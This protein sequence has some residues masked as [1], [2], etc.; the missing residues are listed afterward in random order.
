LLLAQ[1]LWCQLPQ[2]EPS[3]YP[4]ATLTHERGHKH[5]ILDVNYLSKQQ[6]RQE[7]QQQLLS[8]V[9]MKCYAAR[10]AAFIRFLDLFVLKLLCRYAKYHSFGVC[11]HDKIL[12]DH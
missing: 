6:K 11:M 8:D 9:T 3:H 5:H 10:V 4:Y 12:L 2:G 7:Q 1:Q